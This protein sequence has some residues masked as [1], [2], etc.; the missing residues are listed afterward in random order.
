LIHKPRMLVMALATFAHDL[1]V[2]KQV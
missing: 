2:A 1:K